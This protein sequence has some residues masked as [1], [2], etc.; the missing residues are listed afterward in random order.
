MQAA[1]AAEA[2][3]ALAFAKAASATE[4]EAAV[5]SE[6]SKAAEEGFSLGPEALDHEDAVLRNLD[7]GGVEPIR[8][9]TILRRSKRRRS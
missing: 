5:A 8:R 4:L 2:A 7:K 1:E 6:R 3:E 9:R